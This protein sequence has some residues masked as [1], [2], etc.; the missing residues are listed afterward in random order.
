MAPPTAPKPLYRKITPKKPPTRN[1]RSVPRG[2]YSLSNSR[3]SKNKS[4]R[5]MNE[6]S[7]ALQGNNPGT[8]PKSTAK[9]EEWKDREMLPIFGAAHN[10]HLIPRPPTSANHSSNS[11][12]FHKAHRMVQDGNIPL[13]IKMENFGFASNRPP[14]SSSTDFH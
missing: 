4:S 8:A 6:K 5:Q 3:L 13:L 1:A 12:G 10:H 14:A 11:R 9:L 2:A 7:P